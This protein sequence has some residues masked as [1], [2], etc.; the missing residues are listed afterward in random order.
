MD[1]LGTMEPDDGALDTASAEPCMD[2]PP[3]I[4]GNE[5][6]MHVRAYTFWASL[7]NGRVFPAR[8]D[9]DPG[10]IPDFG[11]HG[12]L[13]DFTASRSN[14]AIAFIGQALRDEGGH[15]GPV[16]TLAD[17]PGRSLLS[18]LAD[19]YQEVV[20][21]RAPVGFE[22]EFENVRGNHAL[23]RGILM[24]FSSDG[25]EI[26]FLYGVI[27]WKEVA[28]AGLTA[29]IA[30]EVAR[31]PAPAPL[32]SPA[33]AAW[34]DGPSRAAGRTACSDHDRLVM[35]LLATAC[36]G[37]DI[38]RSTEQRARTAL[39]RVIGLAYDVLLATDAGAVET[40]RAGLATRGT[41][42]RIAATVRAIFGNDE[43]AH[44]RSDYAAALS[45]G[46]RIGIGPGALRMLLERRDGGLRAIVA[47]ERQARRDQAGG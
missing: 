26:D 14:P 1:T 47:D 11:P 8:T 29:G 27:N 16:A 3:A 43:P 17:I 2:P 5:R 4:G 22:A 6:R 25:R 36:E 42:L 34:A 46:L 12:V 31:A 33:A 40:M 9:L 38:A 13:L 45:H 39:Y 32:R 28:D 7:L 35:E 24:P 44:R 30:A 10:A 20:S 19:H 23:Y 15:G 21:N 37:V 18:R 41:R